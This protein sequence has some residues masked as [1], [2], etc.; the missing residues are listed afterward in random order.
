[1]DNNTNNTNDANNL[2]RE[3]ARWLALWFAERKEVSYAQPGDEVPVVIYGYQHFGSGG[4]SAAGRVFGPH[5]VVGTQRRSSSFTTTTVAAVRGEHGAVA[6]ST[7][8]DCL[9]GFGNGGCGARQWGRR[10]VWLSGLPAEPERPE[11]NADSAVWREFHRAQGGRE[12]CI[13]AFPAVIDVLWRASS[14]DTARAL[15]ARLAARA[16]EWGE[17]EYEALLGAPA[18]L[19]ILSRMR[20]A[21]ARDLGHQPGVHRVPFAITARAVMSA[22]AALA[23]DADLGAVCA[24]VEAAMA[25]EEAHVAGLIADE[26]AA[27]EAARR[28][29][30]ARIAA[31]EAARAVRTPPPKALTDKRPVRRL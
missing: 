27:E 10:V 8:S 16:A 12:R 31:E 28:R 5:T 25:A 11:Y 7:E 24:A 17:D 26:R 29:A 1:M 15:D 21:A 18:A 14:A 6:E 19:R 9:G 23:S 3:G 22:R 2:G 13:M 20:R 4:Y 30:E